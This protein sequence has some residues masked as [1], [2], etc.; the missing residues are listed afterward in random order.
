MRKECDEDG[1]L[2]VGVEVPLDVSCDEVLEILEGEVVVRL[3][4]GV[5]VPV[6]VVY[7]EVPVRVERDE[8]GSPVEDVKL[9]VDVSCDEVLLTEEDEG[10][11][12]F[13]DVEVPVDVSRDEVSLTVE[14]NEDVGLSEDVVLVKLVLLDPG[15]EVL[16]GRK[17]L[18]LLLLLLLED[19]LEGVLVE[20]VLL[21]PVEEVLVGRK[22]LLLLLLLLED[23]LEGVPGILVLEMLVLE[24]LSVIEVVVSTL[25]VLD[26]FVSVTVMVLVRP[27]LVS[28][29][30]TVVTVMVLVRRL[31]VSD[32]S[33]VVTV[34]VIV[35]ALLIGVVDASGRCFELGFPGRIPLIMSPTQSA[36]PSPWSKSQPGMRPPSWFGN[37]VGST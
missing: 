29:G 16:V 30:S 26:E 24:G 36:Q 11:G 7:V 9:S 23:T 14:E 10:P 28:D 33:I 15:E 31:L 18:L 27:P 20:L 21:D 3:R 1:S 22:S 32:G 35:R 8:D 4:E 37:R 34:M 25:L 13:E 12:R 19:T 6:L 5:D 2:P 17:S